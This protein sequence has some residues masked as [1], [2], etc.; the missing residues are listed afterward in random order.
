MELDTSR[1]PFGSLIDK[2]RKINNNDD[3]F[4]PGDYNYGLPEEEEEN[5]RV[6]LRLFLVFVV[7]VSV[8]VLA[9]YGCIF[10]ID[11]VILCQYRRGRR[12]NTHANAN[13]NA[14]TNAEGGTGASTTQTTTNGRSGNGG[15][16]VELAELELEIGTAAT[17][18]RLELLDRLTRDERTRLF[19][20]VLLFR[21]VTECDIRDRKEVAAVVA[22]DPDPE[23]DPVEAPSGG[24]EA[25]SEPGAGADAGASIS[26][27]VPPVTGDD[28]YS[29]VQLCCPICIQDV[30]VGDG[31][32]HSRSCSHLFHPGCIVDWLSTGSN[33]CPYC[34]R[35]ILTTAVLE[36]ALRDLKQPEVS[37]P[38]K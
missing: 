13:A 29:S 10:F 4:E 25:E 38:A 7:F 27:A 22:R 23:P 2:I 3:D 8:L 35:V 20:S 32:C 12:R 6:G 28:S 19:S 16:D 37:P 24:A 21:Q 14:N 5:E 33:L 36:E 26:V 11:S 18:K 15:P 9:R 34:R 30:R 1:L 17:K 31:V